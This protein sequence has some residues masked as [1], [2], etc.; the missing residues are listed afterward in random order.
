VGASVGQMAAATTYSTPS[1]TVSTLAGQLGVSGATND[2]GT[3]ASF[4]FVSG[5]NGAGGVAVDNAGNLYVADTYNHKIRKVTAAGVVTTFAGSGVSG[6]TDDTGTAASFNAPVG[7]T[8][9]TQNNLYV[10]DSGNNKIRKIT[11]GGVVTTFAGSGSSGLANGTGIAA[12]F[13]SPTGISVD[14]YGNVYVGD[15]GNHAIRKITSLGVVS[16]PRWHRWSFRLHQCDW[17]RGQF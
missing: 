4:T 1:Y 17:H 8:I 13:N 3:A 12:T 6:S 14:S 2:T 9:D 15:K 10:A 16:T 11:S 7:I 5:G